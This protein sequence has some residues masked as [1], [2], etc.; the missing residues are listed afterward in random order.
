MVCSDCCVA[1]A[2]VAPDGR[3]WPKA[4]AVETVASAPLHD[5]LDAKRTCK[6]RIVSVRYDAPL[7][8]DL[9]HRMEALVLG[10]SD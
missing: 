7:V 3:A 8:E 9:K 1:A 4:V 10:S 5:E 6:G 2:D